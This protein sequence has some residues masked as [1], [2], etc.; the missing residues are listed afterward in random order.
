MVR[1]FVCVRT[2]GHADDDGVVNDGGRIQLDLV[3]HLGYVYMM[4]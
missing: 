2:D 3:M 1:F 4:I